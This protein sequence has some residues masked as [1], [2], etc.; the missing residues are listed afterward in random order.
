MNAAVTPDGRA[1]VVRVTLPVKP[2]LGVTVMVLVPGVPEITVTVAREVFS[3]NAAAG[4][5][6]KATPTVALS[7]P[8]VA[9]MVTL[10]LLAEALGLAAIV[11]VLALDATGLKA[12]V[13]P[14][15][16]PV[17]ARVTVPV[18]PLAGAIVTAIEPLVPAPRVSDAGVVVTV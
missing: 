5:M 12:A 4:V 16:S 7:A 11:N 6:V 3:E 15:A 9:V 13:T 17:T 10:P 8:E 14:E 2:A 1:E 18:K